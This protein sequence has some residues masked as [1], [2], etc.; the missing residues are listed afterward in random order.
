DKGVQVG[1]RWMIDKI[2]VTEYLYTNV[3]EASSILINQDFVN[4]CTEKFDENWIDKVWNSG[5]AVA[6]I[7]VLDL[8][9]IQ[10]IEFPTPKKTNNTLR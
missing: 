4:E 1:L 8:F 10:V 6:I 7:G 9:N 5:F 3:A 2:G